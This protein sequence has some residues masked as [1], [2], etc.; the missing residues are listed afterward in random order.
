MQNCNVQ[1]ALDPDMTRKMDQGSIV[2]W[3]KRIR[4]QMTD[5]EIRK[6][7]NPRL[8]VRKNIEVLKEHGIEISVG[9]LHQWIKEYVR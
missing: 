8:S 7:Y 5:E 9:R 1:F 4:K 3:H 6:W 2:R